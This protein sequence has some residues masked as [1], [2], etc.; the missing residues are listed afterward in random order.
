M[1]AAQSYRRRRG[2]LNPALVVVFMGVA[3]VGTIATLYAMGEIQLS[4]LSAKQADEEVDRP[5]TK[6]MVPVPVAAMPI[7]A[8]TEVQLGHL[9]DREAGGLKTL[10]LAKGN[11]RPEIIKDV[12]KIK[13]RVLRTDVPANFPFT[14]SLF[15]PKGTR[16]GRAAGIPPGKS[17][18]T[19]EANAV[20]G[21]H[22]LRQGDRFDISATLPIETDAEDFAETLDV[23]GPLEQDIA[24][25]SKLRFDKLARVKFI[26][27]NGIVVEP[28]HMRQEE[29]TDTSLMSG[30]RQKRKQIEEIFIAVEPDEAGPLLA[31]IATGHVMTCHPRSGRPDDPMKDQPTPDLEPRLPWTAAVETEEGGEAATRPAGLLENLQRIETIR[32]E[33][34]ESKRDR[35]R[36]PKRRD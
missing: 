16:P 18:L 33:N 24:L 13:G 19:L 23:T 32:G 20:K 35:V 14:E 9:I 10:Y 36:V 21:F 3:V 7:R 34:G 26:V 22:G 12:N 1:T 5:S 6:G 25:E 8:Y 11:L 2:G 31:A 15:Y 4:F 30:T 28:V 17:G 29:F 27:Q